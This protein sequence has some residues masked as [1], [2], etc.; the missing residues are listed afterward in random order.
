MSDSVY[1][2]CPVCDFNQAVDPNHGIC[3]R[4]GFHFAYEDAGPEPPSFYHAR[5]RKVW[6]A[7][8][9]FWPNTAVYEA[10]E[11]EEKLKAELEEARKG[12]KDCRERCAKELKSMQA[13][14]DEAKAKLVA[15]QQL[16]DGAI[17]EARRQC[18]AK[19]ELESELAKLRE[20]L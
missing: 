5:A 10:M 4:C 20:R 8:D 14:V 9:N 16:A 13:A 7:G 2:S 18:A 11:R 3:R 12:W 19:H 6:E 17:D 15:E 1:K